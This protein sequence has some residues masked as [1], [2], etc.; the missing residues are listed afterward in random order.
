MYRDYLQYGIKIKKPSLYKASGEDII[1]L[2]NIKKALKGTIY[3]Y[4]PDWEYQTARN[5]LD[6][7]LL[8][9][10]SAFDFTVS[11]NGDITNPSYWPWT[12]VI[13]SAHANGVK[14]ILT[15][16][17]F[18]ASQ[19]HT[20]LTDAASKSNFFN[21]LKTKIIAYQLDGVNIDFENLSTSDRGSILNTF[22]QDLSNYIHTELPGKEV[23]FAA[24]AVNWGG[25][26][27]S[28]LANACDY[29]F[30]MGYSY[31]GSW[32][33][34]TGPVAP[35]TGGSINVSNTVNTQYAS[36]TSSK[37]EK[38]ILG[39][40]YYGEK[41]K[42]QTSAEA[43][44]VTSYISS[45]RYKNDYSAGNS[46]GVIWSS[47]KTPWYRYQE[48][49]EWYQVWYDN[50]SS[51]GLK[52]TL[53]QSKNFKGVGMW[54]LG[55]DGDRKELWN[56]LR[57]R[58]VSE[59]DTI[60]G[61]VLLNGKPLNNITV[62]IGGSLSSSC[63]TNAAGIYSFLVPRGGSYTI[64]PSNSYYSFLPTNKSIININ[65]N[66]HQDFN[67]SHITKN[68]CGTVLKDG[69]GLSGIMIYISGDMFDSTLTDS[70]GRFNFTVN[71]GRNYIIK[72][73]N[74]YYTFSPLNQTYNEISN[75]QTCN[76]TA[77]LKSYSI[78][79]TV[80]LSGSGLGDVAITI[81]PGN[82]QITTLSIG[83][84]NISGLMH[85]IAYT[86]TPYKSN[87]HFDPPSYT[88]KPLIGDSI[89]NFKAY[90]N[91]YSISGYVKLNSI[92][93]K[94]VR[95]NIQPTDK[96]VIS[97]SSGY[98]IFTGLKPDNEYS[99]MP[100]KKYYNFNPSSYIFYGLNGDTSVNFLSTIIL[101]GIPILISP[102]FGSQNVSIQNIF[103]WSG[104]SN[105]DY[106][107]LQ[108]AKDSNFIK[109]IV[110]K[111]SM[112]VDTFKIISGLEYGTTYYWRIKAWNEA[113]EAVFSKTGI[114]KTLIPELAK[115]IL[116]FPLNNSANMENN[117]AL[118]WYGNN[119]AEKYHLMVSTDSGLI[120]NIILSDSTIRDTIREINN[121]KYHKKYFWKI[122][123][124][125]NNKLSDWSDV[126]CFSTIDHAPSP[127]KLLSPLQNE[128][129]QVSYP[130]TRINFLWNKSI[131][132]D[133]EDRV[134]YI[135]KLSGPD[136]AETYI[137]DDTMKVF[138]S[139]KL[140]ENSEYFWNI[141][142][143]DGSDSI[144][145]GSSRF[146]TSENTIEIKKNPDMKPFEFSLK[147]NYPNPFNPSTKIEYSIPAGDY[148][149]LKVY[150]SIGLEISTLVSEYQQ[151][152]GHFVFWKPENL[153]S[154]IYFYKL[155]TTKNSEMKKMIY[156]R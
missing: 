90:I 100:S 77:V 97:D 111:D 26:D 19:I 20:L 150:N 14:V 12:D 51:L 6:Y 81:N 44:K 128:K 151:A 55:Y 93:L 21:N 124:I 18:T 145:S 37:P 52:Y 17:N 103:L 65:G 104:V 72:P 57:R 120:R 39:V 45:T 98:Y 8:T 33:T 83:Y 50:D 89:K 122:R 114:F 76:F 125:N 15:A 112:I 35:F 53:A 107:F 143:T 136:L 68:I 73:E 102:G 131:D 134:Q 116:K 5:Y 31:Y 32:S 115:P 49:G 71:A 59:I 92:P 86:V 36:V 87:Y 106:Y 95:L 41:W 34:N 137:I 149:S 2:K 9:H 67:A 60:G 139:N 46:Y 105:T 142:S 126:W 138:S 38:L 24:P 123:S 61:T 130:L 64:T 16:V 40:P 127:A 78:R 144:N 153:S 42:T 113:G 154:G 48:N 25:W 94:G 66:L 147:N 30:I 109:D 62:N 85:G 117:I 88:F 91:E 140:K 13:N 27:L 152:G 133:E 110:I 29:L 4:L 121:L 75:N 101:P 108:I 80:T 79:G 63:I 118:K 141:I 11:A 56:E 146:K 129:V 82:I 43:S 28:G 155:K 156:I 132:P 69:N 135:F 74:N 22:I 10:I 3:G 70:L 84:Y 7:N 99:V 96:N 47:F 58:F 148:V 54:A 119:L 1:P 23:S